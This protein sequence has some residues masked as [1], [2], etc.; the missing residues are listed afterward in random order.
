[1]TE[2]ILIA[3]ILVGYLVLTLAEYFRNDNNKQK[4]VK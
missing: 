3:I 1:M 2:T 4:G